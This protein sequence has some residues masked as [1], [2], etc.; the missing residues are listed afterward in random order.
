MYND[1]T[2]LDDDGHPHSEDLH[3]T[4]RYRR[5]DFGPGK[6]SPA[7]SKSPQDGLRRLLSEPTP[8]HR[9]WAT[10]SGATSGTADRT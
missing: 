5:P 2:W 4:E 7:V 10:A 6:V 3:V 9:L 1:K 8:S